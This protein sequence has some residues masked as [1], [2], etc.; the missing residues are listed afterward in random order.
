MC[1]YVAEQSCLHAF[2][3]ACVLFC[4]RAHPQPARLLFAPFAEKVV[5]SV[6][7]LTLTGGAYKA[8]IF[9]A[10]HLDLCVC[11]CLH[12]QRALLTAPNFVA[13]ARNLHKINFVQLPRGVPPEGL[14]S[15]FS[16]FSF[17]TKV[18]EQSVRESALLLP[19]WLLRACTL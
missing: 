16:P 8:V 17:L 19:C 18:I 4:V 10:L 6:I 3:M 5:M 15:L 11:T 7:E 12:V 1:Q 13:K 9:I 14:R 2:M